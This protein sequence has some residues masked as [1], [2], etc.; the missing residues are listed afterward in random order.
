MELSP[1]NVRRSTCFPIIIFKIKITRNG[2]EKF[3]IPRFLVDIRFIEA[4][5]TE[6]RSKLDIHILSICAV[7]GLINNKL[8]LQLF[9]QLNFD[10]F[11]RLYFFP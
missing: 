7:C 10:Y 3:E 9:A 4:A 8:I 2:F 1:T 5:L 6:N 11:G